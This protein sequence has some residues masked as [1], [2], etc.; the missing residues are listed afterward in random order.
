MLFLECNGIGK[1]LLKILGEIYKDAH[2]V[3]DQQSDNPKVETTSYISHLFI[4]GVYLFISLTLPCPLYW[5]SLL[6]SYVVY[7][8]NNVRYEFQE[9]MFW[10]LKYFVCHSSYL[11]SVTIDCLGVALICKP[12]TTIPLQLSFIVMII[13]THWLCS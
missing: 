3:D 11:V 9:Y 1:W 2:V 6:L 10:I 7:W 13:L 4:F 5:V 12:C 8:C